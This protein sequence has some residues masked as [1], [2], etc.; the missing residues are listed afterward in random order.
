MRSATIAV[1]GLV[2][3][4]GAA[5]L[6]RHHYRTRKK[7]IYQLRSNIE[8]SLCYGRPNVKVTVIESW[9]EW[10]TCGPPFTVKAVNYGIIGFDV[11]WVNDGKIALMQL[12]L[13]NGHCLLIRMRW[14]SL[15]MSVSRCAASGQYYTQSPFDLSSS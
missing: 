9:A 10:E 2:T 1:L 14:T 8:R 7:N 5:L 12:A 6:I 11:E 13:P 15:G 3:A 4:S